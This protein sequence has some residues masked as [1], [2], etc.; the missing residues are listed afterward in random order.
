M[1]KTI[2]DV[3]SKRYS[4]VIGNLNT[5]ML[6]NLIDVLEENE[7]PYIVLSSNSSLATHRIGFPHG[8]N[9]YIGSESFY[10]LRLEAEIKLINRKF[11][12]NFDKHYINYV[13]EWIYNRHVMSTPLNYLD[14]DGK[15]FEFL[16]NFFQQRNDLNPN[17]EDQIAVKLIKLISEFYDDDASLPIV[18]LRKSLFLNPCVVLVSEKTF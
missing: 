14:A 4:A 13:V 12:L 10:K 2:L 1:E 3:I 5:A 8:I 11:N 15:L 7:Y 17:L 18:Q 6:E 9:E 16:E